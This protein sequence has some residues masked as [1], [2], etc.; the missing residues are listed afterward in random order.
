MKMS[1]P[2]R[3]YETGYKENRWTSSEGHGTGEWIPTL[4]GTFDW[5]EDHTTDDDWQKWGEQIQFHQ[6]LDPKWFVPPYPNRY[7]R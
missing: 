1:N 4:K 6:H 5:A 2:R 3:W 7:K